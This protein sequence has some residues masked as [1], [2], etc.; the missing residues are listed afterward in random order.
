MLNTDQG[1]ELEIINDNTVSC[2]AYLGFRISEDV[3]IEQYSDVLEIVFCDVDSDGLGDIV[4][5][6]SDGSNSIA[7]LCMVYVNEWDEG[8]AVGEVAVTEWLNENVSDMTADN[9]IGYPG[10]SGRV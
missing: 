4:G 8:Y 5:I 1:L 9:V 10:S 2:V 7:I 6:L 3:D